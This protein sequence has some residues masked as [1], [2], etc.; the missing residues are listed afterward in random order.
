MKSNVPWSVKGIE[1]DARETAKL[2]AKRQGMTLGEWLNHVIRNASVSAENGGVDG[3]QAADLI[4]AIEHLNQRV[5]DTDDSNANTIKD[6]SRS[7]G[8]VVERVQRLER[9]T[10]G[11]AADLNGESADPA[12]AD[13][14]KRLEDTRRNDL[15]RVEALKALER[16]VSQVAVQ[17]DKTQKDAAKRI[18]ENEKAIER[19]TKAADAPNDNADNETVTA[20][21]SAVEGLSNRLT[22]AERIADEAQKLRTE[23][24]SS[25]D[26]DFVERTGARLRVLGDEIK[27]GG[28]QIRT[29]EGTIDKLSRQIEAAEERSSESVQKVSKTITNLREELLQAEDKETTAAAQKVENAVK[30]ATE[31]TDKRIEALQQ[32]F[33]VLMAQLGPDNASGTSNAVAPSADQPLPNFDLIED[34]AT[35]DDTL[36]DAAQ[37][38]QA[39]AAHNADSDDATDNAQLTDDL[40]AELAQLD[41][42]VGEKPS[43]SRT[44]SLINNVRA[45][46]K[47][48][49]READADAFSVKQNEAPETDSEPASETAS[50][51]EA[52]GAL[53]QDIDAQADDGAEADTDTHDDNADESSIAALLDDFEPQHAQQESTQ[54]ETAS[55][56]SVEKAVAD[57]QDGLAQNPDEADIEAALEG[58]PA[59]QSTKPKITR[60]QLTPKQKAIL[61]A[62]ARKKRLEE[63]GLAAPQIDAL[64]EHSPEVDAG[65]DTASA[66]TTVY[67]P[68]PGAEDTYESETEFGADADAAPTSLSGRVSSALTARPVTTA[69]VSAILL[70]GTA[71]VFMVQDLVFAPKTP[72]TAP[73]VQNTD[74]RQPITAPLS[75]PQTPSA[76]ANAGATVPASQ[77]SSQIPAAPSID[78]VK[79]YVDASAALANATS[80]AQK[81]DAI[82]QLQEAANLGHP[83]AQLQVGELLKTGN[84]VPQ[85]LVGARRNFRNAANGGNVLA[86]HRLGIMAA[87]G[88]GG[89]NDALLAIRWFEQAANFGLVDAQFNLGAIFQPAGQNPVAPQ[90]AAKS[91]MWYSIAA[92]SGDSQSASLAEGV[93]ATLSASKRLEL[94]TFV[95][96]WS[97]QSQN[98]VANTLAPSV[99]Q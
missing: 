43:P 53:E 80:E 99:S 90:D 27:R 52:V 28:D 23:A 37:N 71:L 11:G 9:G 34:D 15:Q 41:E 54:S 4:T 1:R 77:P 89:P 29:L 24:Q 6:I 76:Q 64:A 84:G 87:R 48:S 66:A 69:L 97:A 74:T 91:Y 18:E 67:T 20:L 56:S 31:R 65:A 57:Q 60:R 72:T 7:L 94:D 38:A 93:G 92:K 3:V 59:P 63:A 19:L 5:A 61:A 39:Q 81:T 96:N 12:I 32:S 16:A 85:D 62:R 46:F 45:A 44:Q 73:F 98:S 17:F 70:A 55:G 26:K 2:A 78:P 8:S 36:A 86:M 95:K 10:G 33:D 40:E 22:Q 47:R 68:L 35:R 50:E 49:E 75:A 13:R 83:P 42:L 58:T 21:K 51:A 25:F 88:E 82:A 30:A 14:L 79:L